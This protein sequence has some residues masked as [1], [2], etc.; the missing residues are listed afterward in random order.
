M[1]RLLL[2]LLVIAGTASADEYD[3]ARIELNTLF[4]AYA[5]S[6]RFR[7]AAL[8]SVDGNIL[9][10]EGYGLAS[11]EWG[12]ANSPTTRFST[13]SLTK[14]FTATAALALVEQGRLN[15]D[16]PVREYLPGLREDVGSKVTLRTILNHSSGLRREVFEESTDL[17]IVHQSKEILAA[18]NSSGLEF[19]PGEQRSYS[20]VGYVLVRLILEAVEHDTFANTVQRLVFDPAGMKDSGFKSST[21]VVPRL[22]AGYDVILG[23][24]ILAEPSVPE[25]GLGAGGMYT[26]VLDL[27][28]FDRALRD[29]R[30]LS[31]EMQGERL[32]SRIQGWGL[33]WQLM[34]V[35]EKEDGEPEFAVFHNGDWSGVATHYFRYPADGLVIA[36]LSNQAD[37]S[38]TEMFQKITGIINGGT[39][40]PPEP[41][42]S[43]ELYEVVVRNGEDA[44]L[45]LAESA[46]AEGRRGVPHAMSIIQI[47]N[48]LSRMGQDEATRRIYA[49]AALVDPSAPWGHLGLGQW[50]ETQGRFEEARACYR[51]VLEQDPQQPHALAY[52]KELAQKESDPSAP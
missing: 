31:A 26:T 19:E 5:N 37:L 42:L 27:E 44:G 45:A 10:A 28:A 16:T 14:T 2:I 50:Y 43:D 12:I 34:T 39:A 6:G 52:L 18:I 17:L 13:A 4:E 48:A 3:H 22:A 38:R 46:R 29:H 47:G 35:G 51:Q 25:N 15:L 7:G 8:V 36:L 41:R 11:E 24:V 23:E 30:I 33:G 49:F 20:N 9:L 40:S 21:T 1:K 32:R